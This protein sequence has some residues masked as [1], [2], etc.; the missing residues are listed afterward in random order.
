M[1]EQKLRIAIISSSNK[2]S[3]RVSFELSKLFG[4]PHI[5]SISTVNADR[6]ICSATNKA[7]TFNE[8]YSM[9][10]SGFY[11]RIKEE[12]IS[13]FI[14]DG[15]VL[16]VIASKK[17]EF[18]PGRPA[19]SIFHFVVSTILAS[20]FREF[21]NKIESVIFDYAE[22]AY[23]K[24]YLI[25]HS[26]LSVGRYCSQFD[27][28]VINMLNDR[29]IDYAIIT[30]STDMGLQEIANDIKSITKQET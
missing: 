14:S 26:G 29:K 18:T 17:A 15:S 3:A 21:E 2:E 28:F 8:T 24:V 6:E 19:K 9:I 27:I 23:D 4:I 20:R 11:S 22:K 30:D 5:P 1:K 12:K 10:L 7:H 13:N 16:D 25:R